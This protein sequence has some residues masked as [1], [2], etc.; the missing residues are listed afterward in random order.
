MEKQ[1]KVANTPPL[2]VLAGAVVAEED[3]EVISVVVVETSGAKEDLLRLR[4][5]VIKNENRTPRKNRSLMKNQGDKVISEVLEAVAGEV[6]GEVG[7][8]FTGDAQDLEVKDQEM[9]IHLMMKVV[10]M[11]LE[12]K[13]KG[14]KDLHL[15]E[16]DRGVEDDLEGSGDDQDKDHLKVLV[17]KVIGNGSKVIQIGIMKSIVIKIVIIVKAVKEGIQGIIV[18]GNLAKV[19]GGVVMLVSEKAIGIVITKMVNAVMVKVMTINVVA[20]FKMMQYTR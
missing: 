6:E 1:S 19:I 13:M 15:E 4:K 5:E 17:M 14:R 2:D 8:V 3:T 7:V 11:M 9:S 12:M 10:M 18:S 16:E 20:I